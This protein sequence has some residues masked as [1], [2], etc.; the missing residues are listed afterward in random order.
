VDGWIREEDL[1]REFQ[2]AQDQL[3]PFGNT[4]PVPVWGLKGITIK[5]TQKVGY[6]KKHL[7]LMFDTAVGPRDAIG[8][9][10]GDRDLPKGPVDL[11]FQLRTNVFRGEESLQLLLQDL[12]PSE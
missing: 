1:T 8:F 7:R 4:N 5:Y 10:F 12:R 9:G 11:A 6:D 2:A 3:M